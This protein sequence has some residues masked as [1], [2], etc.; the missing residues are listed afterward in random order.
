MNPVLEIYLLDDDTVF[1]SSFAHALEA[2]L[3]RQPYPYRLH[4]FSSGGALLSAAEENQVDLLIS[5]IDLRDENFSGLTV[6]RRIRDCHP[7]CG[8]IFLTSFLQYATEIYETR[9]LYFILKEEYTQRITPAMELY[10][11]QLEA[12]METMTLTSGREEVVLRLQDL[13]YCER[14]GRKTRLVC[15]D[16]ELTIIPGIEELQNSL[17]RRQFVITHKSF[18]VNLKYVKSHLRFEA[19]LTTGQ[20]IPISRSRYED[21]RSAFMA[22][23]AE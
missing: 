22:F 1:L 17:P 2:H 10:F 18:I 19:L 14:S 21:F 8:I 5:D 15:Q 20:I 13:I 6:A 12:Q 3:S 7:D 11:R 9:P 4:S 16:R 23:L